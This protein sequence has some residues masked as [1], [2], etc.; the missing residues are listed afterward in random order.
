MP[1]TYQYPRPAVTADI[2]LIDLSSIKPFVLLI[3]RKNTPYKD[4]WAFPGGF[5][6][7]DETLLEAAY[8]ELFEETGVD[9]VRLEQFKTYDSINRDPRQ[10]TISTVFLGI[11]NKEA[12][13]KAGDDAS[14]AEWVDINT[15][16]E[17]AFDHN[18]I[19]DDIKKHYSIK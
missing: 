4:C 3:K 6:E 12:H 7:M 17:L 2:V 19:L 14:A 9:N 1:Y 5:I 18:L 8:R 15:I 13:F 11:G 16:K 10:R